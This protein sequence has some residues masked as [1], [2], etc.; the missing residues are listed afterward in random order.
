MQYEILSSKVGWAVDSEYD[1]RDA[2]DENLE[3]KVNNKISEGWK[4]LG[5]VSM[6]LIKA[7]DTSQYSKIMFSQAMIKE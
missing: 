2:A 6:I 1:E 3:T 7:N 4:P 5:G